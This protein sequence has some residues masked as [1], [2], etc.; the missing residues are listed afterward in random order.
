L[1]TGARAILVKGGTNPRYLAS[2]HLT[3]AHAGAIW[4][5]KFD[6]NRLAVSGP[7]A[8]VL[9]GVA[10]SADGAAQFAV[11]L[12]GTTVYHPAVPRSSR[13]L[14]VVDGRSQ[15]PL[16]APP[17]AYVTPRVSPD[18]TRVL[19]GVADDA[20]HVWSY[21][22]TAGTLT[23]LTFEAANR[24]PIWSPDGMRVTFASNRNGQLNLF[25]VPAT[26]MARPNG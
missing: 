21:D 25:V 19:L 1:R 10:T 16:A 22:L 8:R 24:S 23:Q 18:G 2:G 26:P 17:H 4:A 12:A 20:E 3:Y 11:S 14:I 6:P 7:P 9:D 15:T 5:V 13:R